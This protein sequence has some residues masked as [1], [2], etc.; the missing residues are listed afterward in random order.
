MGFGAEKGEYVVIKLEKRGL[1]TLRAVSLLAR[2]LDIPAEN[3]YIFGLKDKEASTISYVFAR[4]ALIDSSRLPVEMKNLKAEIIGYT[5][6]K[7]TPRYHVGNKFTI[8]VESVDESDIETF[9][10]IVR[11]IEDF[12]LP[13]YYGYQR[14]GYH[15]SNSHILGKYLLLLREDLFAD[16]LLRRLYPHEDSRVYLKRILR[17]YRDLHYEELYIKIDKGDTSYTPLRKYLSI[18]RDAYSSYL[19]NLLLNNVIEKLGWDQLNRDYPLPGCVEHAES[20]YSDLFKFEV[21]ET[22]VLKHLLCYYRRGLFKPLQSVIR[23]SASTIRYEF[24]LSR[25][26]YATIV[27]REVFK[28]NLSLY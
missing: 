11:R 24:L 8:V 23:V 26:M 1:E 10:S 21:L 19:F 28:D 4:R 17:D 15:R 12:G 6:I 3:L 27:L 5:R 14:F 22:S 9:K 25:G 16:E 18:L 13:S 20:L 2:T 7:P